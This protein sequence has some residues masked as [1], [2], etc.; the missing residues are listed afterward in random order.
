MSILLDILF[1]FSSLSIIFINS[2]HLIFFLY[3]SNSIL[4]EITCVCVW[5]SFFYTYHFFINL[6][7]FYNRKSILLDILYICVPSF[8]FFYIKLI[9]FT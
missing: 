1:V 3:K 2:D 4:L 9:L 7:L 8:H 5:F 6:I